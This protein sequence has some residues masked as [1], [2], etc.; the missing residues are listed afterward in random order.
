MDSLLTGM[1]LLLFPVVPDDFANH[2]ILL[3]HRMF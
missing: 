3:G 2:L 1:Y